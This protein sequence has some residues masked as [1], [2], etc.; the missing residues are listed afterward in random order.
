MIPL[1]LPTFN[2]NTKQQQNKTYILDV[3]RKKYLLLTPEE[4]VRQHILHYLIH[5]LSYPKGLFRLEK[6]INGMR[7]Y[8][9]PDIV[10]CDKF[11][12]ARMIIECKSPSIVLTDTTLGQIMR[13]NRQLCVNF[14]LITN[15][16]THFC[17]QLS[18]HAQ[19]VKTWKYIP[20]YK[21]LLKIYC[22]HSLT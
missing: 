17:W 1:T 6:K 8:Y 5:Y 18:T 11:G 14:L 9:R 21:E 10:L 4:W 7:E 22:D 2:Y 12:I 3:I 13:Y 20:D 16:I 15:G 19:Q